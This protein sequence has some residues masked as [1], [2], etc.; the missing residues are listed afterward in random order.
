MKYTF[1]T[2]NVCGVKLYQYDPDDEA[3]DSQEPKPGIGLRSVPGGGAF[4]VFTLAAE[5]KIHLCLDC[6]AGIRNLV[7]N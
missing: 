5:E 3:P 4:G 2:C 6:V 7:V 1:Y